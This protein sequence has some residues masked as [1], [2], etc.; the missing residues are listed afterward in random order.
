MANK[1]L[2]GKD[3]FGKFEKTISS[4]LFT[5][6][7][8]VER[9]KLAAELAENMPFVTMPLREYGI[10]EGSQNTHILHLFQPNLWA[11][12][13]AHS[14]GE[15]GKMTI[16]TSIERANASAEYKI[17]NSPGL[18]E[19]LRRQGK[20]IYEFLQAMREA[21]LIESAY[22]TRIGGI[23]MAD[24]LK[25]KIDTALM[26]RA[27]KNESMFKTIINHVGVD[28][29]DFSALFQ[30]AEEMD[31]T[32]CLQKISELDPYFNRRQ[33]Q[34]TMF[35]QIDSEESAKVHVTM[36]NEAFIDELVAKLYKKHPAAFKKISELLTVVS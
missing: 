14:I 10:L 30:F 16:A 15:L 6:E 24:E 27:V 3:V 13:Y 23:D 9:L 7:K 34:I 29:K 8:E 5:K 32:E 28:D 12:D 1:N 2:V 11:Q 25:R 19:L 36:R 33:S 22:Y 4:P 18:S 26:R 31:L 35:S 20:T 21:A 17:E